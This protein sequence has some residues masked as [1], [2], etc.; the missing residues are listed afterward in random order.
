MPGAHEQRHE[1]IMA[2]RDRIT[3]TVPASVGG[4]NVRRTTVN[5][6]R[7]S[8]KKPADNSIGFPLDWGELLKFLPCMFVMSMYYYRSSVL[9]IANF[10]GLPGYSVTGDCERDMLGNRK[11]RGRMAVC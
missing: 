10:N 2:P 7:R 4:K 8:D 6:R 5:S 11:E 1:E 9:G 3:M